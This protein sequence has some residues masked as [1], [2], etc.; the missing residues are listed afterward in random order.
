MFEELANEM[1]QFVNDLE[2]NIENPKDLKYILKPV[3][4]ID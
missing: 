4:L 3:F 1:K 2:D